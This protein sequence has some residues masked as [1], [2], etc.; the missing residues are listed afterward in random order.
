MLTIWSVVGF[1]QPVCVQS[2]RRGRFWSYFEPTRSSCNRLRN[3]FRLRPD[4]FL[5]I[6]VLTLP[7][8]IRD[9]YTGW[10][11]WKALGLSNTNK[12]C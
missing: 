1:E 4:N 8:H 5:P 3:L 2:L 12:V 10:R 7:P 6:K 11:R 9:K